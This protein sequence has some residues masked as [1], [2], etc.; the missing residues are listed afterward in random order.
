MLRS[1]L[2]RLSKV[3]GR[4]MRGRRE[5][6]KKE[7]EGR[8]KKEE[9]LRPERGA[10][11]PS[12]RAWGWGP[13]RIERNASDTERGRAPA[14]GARREAAEGE[15]LGVG[16]QARGEKKS[17]CGPSDPSA[18]LRVVLSLSKGEPP[19]PRLL[20]DV[21][22]ADMRRPV[23]LLIAAAI[24]VLTSFTTA[25]DLVPRVRLVDVVLVFFGA[26]GAGG[27]SPRQS[28][29]SRRNARVNPMYVAGRSPSSC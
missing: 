17:A 10:K 6:R 27:R 2:V 19:P 20:R 9:R 11:P 23:L 13:K 8:R 15:R 1:V 4:V 16:P 21:Y 5:E 25:V 3:A 29:S 12:E 26:F 28:S 14:A 22:F 18:W 24:G 7:E